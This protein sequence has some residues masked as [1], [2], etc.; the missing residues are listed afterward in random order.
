HIVSI[1][2][3]RREGRMLGRWRWRRGRDQHVHLAQHLQ[4]LLAQQ[5]TRLERTVID[6]GRYQSRGLQPRA[7]GTVELGSPGPE[8]VVTRPGSFL[9]T[10]T[11]K[12]SPR[13][14][15]QW[16]R[17]LAHFRPLLPQHL[18]RAVDGLLD[19]WMHASILV[20]FTDQANAYAA[21]VTTETG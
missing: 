9:I 7:R 10:H 19:L 8:D 18:K 20:Q 16:D 14:R 11:D 13:Q 2:E 12:N 6:L 21:Q 5:D 17:D 3:R 15:H 1:D 4:E